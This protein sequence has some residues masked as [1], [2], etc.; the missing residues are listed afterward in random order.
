[1]AH[2]LRATHDA[3]L[4]GIETVLQDDPQL[5]VRHVRGRD[6]LRVVLDSQLRV[7]PN[8]KV[9][10]IFPSGPRVWVATAGGGSRTKVSALEARGIRVVQCPRG[11][12]GGVDLPF[13]LGELGR[14]G[15]SSLLVEGGGR[16]HTA[17]LRSGLAQRLVCFV[18]PLI[19]GSGVDAVGVL[20]VSAVHEALRFASWQVRRSG[21]DMVVDALL[22][23][24]SDASDKTPSP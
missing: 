16:V 17:F 14:S 21:G 3:V 24:S 10:E 20:G 4:V 19:L 2:R 15:I 11:A 7:P 12:D 8:A 6:P 1:M 5:T 13:L 9:M 23:P 22:A 18:G